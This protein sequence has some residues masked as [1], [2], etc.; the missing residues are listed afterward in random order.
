MTEYPINIDLKVKGQG[1][2]NS[3]VSS[4]ERI[5]TT[6]KQTADGIKL[7]N[8]AIN[9]VKGGG[10]LQK[11]ATEL[12]NINKTGSETANTVNKINFSKMTANLGRLKSIDETLKTLLRTVEE[13][14]S[15]S[16][17]RINVDSN[18]RQVTQE[19]NSLNRV[20]TR[21]RKHTYRTGSRNGYNYYGFN[22]DE[23]PYYQKATP[24]LNVGRGMQR[25]GEKAGLVGANLMMAGSF[26]GFRELTDT[27]I[28][29]PAKAETQ[30]Y[31]LSNMQ[32]GA[33][34]NAEGGG[35]T[36][37]YNTLDKVTDQLPISMQNVVQ[38][39]YAFKAA[40]G[41][42]A[43]EIND[44][45][46]EFANFGAQV[47]N[48][49]GSEDQAEE[50]MQ[51]LSRAYQGQ[52]A[53]VDQYGITKESLEKVGYQEGGTIEE[54][55]DAVTQITGDAKQSMN[56][57]NGMKALV[58][59]DFSRAG[60]QIW[61]SGVG[62]AMSSLVSGFHT[63]D[64]ETGGF[65]TSLIVGAASFLE[66]AT[67][68]ATV[69]GSIGTTI[70]TFGQMY[71]NLQMI[72]KNGGG[73]TG[74]IKGIFDGTNN[75]GVYGAGAY[76][77]ADDIIDNGAM[78]TAVYEGALTGTLQGMN[79]SNITGRIDKPT[80]STIPNGA[81][82]L[83]DLYV[84]SR[85]QPELP[86]VY[87][88]SYKNTTK[89]SGIENAIENKKQRERYEQRKSQN[90]SMD[91]YYSDK[92]QRDLQSNATRMFDDWDRQ[93]RNASANAKNGFLEFPD[94]SDVY[95]DHEKKS[96]KQN[97]LLGGANKLLGKFGNAL[98]MLASPT[99]ALAGLSI[100]AM[101][102]GAWISYASAHSDKV[103]DAT[104]NVNRAFNNLTNTLGSA[105]GDFF[106]KIGLSSQG[107]MEGAFE[108]TANALNRLAD[109]INDISGHSPE[110]EKLTNAQ[111]RDTKKKEE[112]DK[113]GQGFLALYEKEFANADYWYDPKTQTTNPVTQKDWEKVD[114]MNN[115]RWWGNGRESIANAIDALTAAMLVVPDTHYGKD[116][117]ADNAQQ[118]ALIKAGDADRLSKR[119]NGGTLLFGSQWLLGKNQGIDLSSLLGISNRSPFEAQAY[120]RAKRD[121]AER[122][123]E[124]PTGMDI[125]N[126]GQQRPATGA[127]NAGGMAQNP[128][129]DG[130]QAGTDWAGQFMAGLTQGFTAHPINTDQI[131]GQDAGNDML[132]KGQEWSTNITT[133]FNEG[134]D[135]NSLDIGNIGGAISS[136]NG[137][138][139]SAGNGLG[140]SGTDG[141]NTGFGDL[142]GIAGSEAGEI[143]SALRA[144]I[145][146]VKQAALEL[147]QASE[148]GFNK[149]PNALNHESPGR[150]AKLMYAEGDEIVKAV[151]AHVNPLKSASTTLATSAIGSFNYSSGGVTSPIGSNVTSAVGSSLD[152][153]DTAS[154][155]GTNNNRNVVINNNFHI[156]KIDSKERVREIAETLVHIMTFNNET[157]GRNTST[158]L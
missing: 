11:I 95:V 41:A 48:M 111:E 3:L 109:I 145:P 158:G 94:K 12:Q 99:G 73:I 139:N 120:G 151:Y 27:V 86:P 114:A 129:G 148:S 137:E 101:G 150:L 51:K 28:E 22:A 17:I 149:D 74:A 4:L 92:E 37:L 142:S 39:L 84:K 18:A 98:E 116:V 67:T 63:L 9:S 87:D 85:T 113:T 108:G 59:K 13:L 128:M 141:F 144:H 156:D 104:T 89:K 29:T 110:E 119:A 97:K 6:S 14:K 81:D 71:G 125:M 103:K 1:S 70:G 57:F 54:F 138:V 88:T 5:E 23:N 53:A 72:R 107:G 75:A 102:A 115:Q 38:P 78:E 133:G 49:T 127:T 153:S 79:S 112:A 130:T 20:S 91:L 136:H 52:Y 80:R 143:A 21:T 25:I 90:P 7:L 40:S 93:E 66:L 35:T 61:N 60:K 34:I 157:A 42:T 105:F 131:L 124:H 96:K 30:K 77:F 100:A 19:L 147:A 64:Q 154:G 65:T 135:P 32:G 106:Q 50:A 123:E 82:D 146:E 140:K 33:T 8:T 36:T 69:A 155:D 10:N 68:T 134:F 2:L 152:N 44:I 47:I 56:N 126:K 122:R 62:Q 121:A 76:G 15:N 118:E 31:L 83:D 26:L 55:M 43:Q 24:I 46:P 58:G 45:L 117:R 132:M 16:N